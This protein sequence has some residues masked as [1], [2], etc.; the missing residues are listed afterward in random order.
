MRSDNILNEKIV[1]DEG[2]FGF[3]PAFSDENFSVVHSFPNLKMFL[4]IE[5]K[6]AI[7]DIF[8]ST[9]SLRSTGM[10]A[11]VVVAGAVVVIETF[12]VCFESNNF[13]HSCNPCSG[14]G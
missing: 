9:G 2:F 4:K 10:G 11:A 7:K 12:V 8:G 14:V 1:L 5:I 3:K 13:Q 6:N